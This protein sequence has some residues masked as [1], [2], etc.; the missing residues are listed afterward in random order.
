VARALDLTAER[1]ARVE[2]ER[3]R[4]HDARRAFLRAIGH[5]LRTPL[6]ALRAALEGVQDGVV[7]DPRRYLDSMQG[8]V[9]ALSALVDDLFVLT[10]IESGQVDLDPSL[11]DLSDLADEALETLRPV[12]DKRDV[13][14]VLHAKGHVEVVGGPAELSR[15][16]RNLVDNAI[17]HCPA[18]GKVVVYVEEN[19]SAEVRVSDDGPG[20]EARYVAD[21]FVSFSRGDA[22][23]ARAGGG[24]GLGL[25]IARGFVEAHG[26]TIWAEPGP[27]GR[28]GFRLPRAMGQGRSLLA[29]TPE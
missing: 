3:D 20:F 25:A 18:A 17:R 15:V 1:L 6:A 8:D 12:A 16:I 19:G 11:V 2:A 5:D 10:R 27:G 9:E 28:V 14:L 23:R 13:E 29:T 7:G 24:S 26:G 21:A 22:A 4:E